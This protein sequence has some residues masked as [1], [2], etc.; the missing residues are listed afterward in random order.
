M[1]KNA[2]DWDANTAISTAAAAVFTAVMAWFT[3][4]AIL[5]RQEVSRHLIPHP[6][7]P[8]AGRVVL[9]PALVASGEGPGPCSY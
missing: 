1:D 3:R 8:V 2:W 5:E 4:K 7:A 9:R 6:L